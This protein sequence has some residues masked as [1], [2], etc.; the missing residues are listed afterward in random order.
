MFLFPFAGGIA[1]TFLEWQALLGADVELHV[2]LLP[3]RGTRL[4][5]L[6]MHDLGELVDHLTGAIA[7]LADKP[8]LL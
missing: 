7:D 1:A 2:A 5:E 4:H 8:F 3:G 6:P